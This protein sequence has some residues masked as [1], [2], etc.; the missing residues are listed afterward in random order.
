MRKQH[1]PLSSTQE[2]SCQVSKQHSDRQ[3]PSVGK[4]KND[5]H[6]AKFKLLQEKKEKK[7]KKQHREIGEWDSD[8]YTTYT[9]FQS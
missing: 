4:H 2:A 9:P 6:A 3:H 8:T 1:A 7:G 5:V